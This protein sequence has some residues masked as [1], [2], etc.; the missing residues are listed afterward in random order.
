MLKHQIGAKD[1]ESGYNHRSAVN[2]CHE[3]VLYFLSSYVLNESDIIKQLKFNIV[4]V[5]PQWQN[6]K[7]T[8]RISFQTGATYKTSSGI[9]H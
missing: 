9:T 8:I 3:L 1:V 5:F 7:L 2:A 6:S 4:C